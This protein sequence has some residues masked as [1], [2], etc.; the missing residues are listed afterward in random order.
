VRTLCTTLLELHSW[1]N[2]KASLSIVPSPRTTIT[3]TFTVQLSISVK[4]YTS[5]D[6]RFTGTNIPM[7]M[8][9]G[10]AEMPRVADI[11]T[12]NS[13]PP[14]RIENATQSGLIQPCNKEQHKQMYHT[15]YSSQKTHYNIVE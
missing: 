12:S 10:T 6:K 1:Q 3:P 7:I 14:M 11:S 2:D 9:T 5:S 15:N 13:R 4:T 8:L